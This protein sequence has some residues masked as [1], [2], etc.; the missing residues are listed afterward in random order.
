[1]MLF[2]LLPAQSLVASSGALLVALVAAR[3]AFPRL[4]AAR[5]PRALALTLA[6]ADLALHGAW[7]FA[8]PSAARSFG[9][10]ALLAL[11]VLALLAGGLVVSALLRALL[12][13]MPQPAPAAHA[14]IAP[15]LA[16]DTIPAPAATTLSRRAFTQGL[17]ASAPVASLTLGGA[18]FASGLGQ[19]RLS[20]VVIPIAE[21]PDALVGLRILQLSDLHLGCTR[22]VADLDRTL[23][24]VAALHGVP[25]LI[26]LTG[27]IAEDVRELEPALRLV[28]SMRPRLGAFACLG[29]HEYLRGIGRARP[30]LER[31][32][33]RLLVDARSDL[34]VGGARLTVA[35]LN[36]PVSLRAPID[37]PLRRSLDRALDGAPSR[38][39]R[40]VLSH[41]PEGFVP[42][43]A[44]GA[45]LVLSGHTHGGQIGFNG[46]SAFEPLFPGAYL[47]GSYL[48]GRSAL[49][50][51]SG[52]GHWYPFRL[53]CP[54][55]A[56]LLE[57]VR[58]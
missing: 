45:H 20:R 27:D 8:A 9:T 4:A 13:R 16:G 7:L 23:E 37:H 46:K 34:V 42:A 48:R 10:L 50:T 12:H 3:A 36:D 25:D 52:Y 18:G 14:A 33:V 47:W 1:M 49:Y 6:A 35:G 5:L 55:E 32:D 21:L 38:A 22:H 39:T 44:L 24:A 17:I 40:L 11:P 19:P 56:P 2:P 15:E 31:S 57:L 54:T 53:G 41:R 43:S 26:A 51:T 58:A 30:V 29:N 28:A